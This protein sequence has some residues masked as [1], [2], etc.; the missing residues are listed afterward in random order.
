LSGVRNDSRL[1][2]LLLNHQRRNDIKAKSIIPPI[3]PPATGPALLAPE[4]ETVSPVVGLID[5]TDSCGDVGEVDVGASAP[6][7]MGVDVDALS[8][9][10]AIGGGAEIEV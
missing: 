4:E 7:S 1:L 9:L 5:T 3:T 2:L 8:S 10:C 6:M